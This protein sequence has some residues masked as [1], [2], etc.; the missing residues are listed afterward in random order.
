[1]NNLNLKKTEI[2]NQGTERFIFQFEFYLFKVKIAGPLDLYV[3]AGS[4]VVL[5]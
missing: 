3:K 5:R 2:L 1:M 4:D